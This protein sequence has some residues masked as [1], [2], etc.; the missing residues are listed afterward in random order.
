MHSKCVQVTSLL[1]MFICIGIVVTGIIM[2]VQNMPD[3][4]TATDAMKEQMTSVGQTLVGAGSTGFGMFLGLNI[5]NVRSIEDNIVDLEDNC[6]VVREKNGETWN[7]NPMPDSR[8]Y[9]PFAPWKHLDEKERNKLIRKWNKDK[10]RLWEE[11]KY[12]IG[13]APIAYSRT[14]RRFGDKWGAKFWTGII[15]LFCILAAVLISSNV[16]GLPWSAVELTNATM[17]LGIAGVFFSTLSAGL[18]ACDTY[19]FGNKLKYMKMVEGWAISNRERDA[20]KEEQIAANKLLQPFAVAQG[21][22][23][24][25]MLK[26]LA[27]IDSDINGTGNS[28]ETKINRFSLDSS[29]DAGTD[30]TGSHEFHGEI[31]PPNK[32]GFIH[33]LPEYKDLPIEIRRRLI[34]NHPL[35]RLVNQ[36][37]AQ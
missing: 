4:D 15:G 14:A 8:E 18:T 31:P 23:L 9:N 22:R 27:S 20:K 24:Q 5:K 1:L 32:R 10:T 19:N 29:E 2:I 11:S 21:E 28:V 35:V 36:I 12:G 13:D 26:Q 34:Q 37:K 25:S 30:S 17:I 6:T 16:F 7:H 33:E 3:D